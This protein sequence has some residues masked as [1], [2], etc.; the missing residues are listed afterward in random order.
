MNM[1]TI[2]YSCCIP[3]EK[4]WGAEAPW[5]Y[6][7]T[8][9]ISGHVTERCLV[10]GSHQQRWYV[11]SQFQCGSN[12]MSGWRDNGQKPIDQSEASIWQ[13]ITA[14]WWYTNYVWGSLRWPHSFNMEAM[15][16]VEI[17]IFADKKV[18]LPFYIFSI[19]ANLCSIFQNP[20][21]SALAR[22]AMLI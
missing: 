15:Q 12:A 9:E 19:S 6:P 20:F 14:A 5:E 4:I 7:S 21:L 10:I 2:V 11:N 16:W 18:I 1:A 3:L 13:K 17:G 22:S 8:S